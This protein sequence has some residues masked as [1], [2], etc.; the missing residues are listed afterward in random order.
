[1]SAP[2]LGVALFSLGGLF[3]GRRL[4]LTGCLEQV[5]ALGPNQGI[6]LVGAQSLRSYPDVSDDEVR[7]F[8]AAVDRTGVVPVSY[9]AYLE[10]ARS[11]TRVLSPLEAVDLVAAEIGV[12]R[13]LGFPMLRVNLVPPEVL[14]ALAR[15]AERTGMPVVIELATEP[16][17][18]PAVAALVEELDRL[19]CPDL[20]VIQDF[21]AFVQAIPA[22]YV[23]DA[24]AAG[25]PAAALDAITDAWSGGR[26][27][28][29]AVTTVL[30]L[31][32][33]T[34]EERGLSV[35]TAHIAY[36]LFRA[37]DPGGLRDVLPHL[38]HVQ[39]KFFALDT[40]DAE[41]CIPCPELITALREGGYTGRIHSE[42]EGF[43]WDDDLDAVDQI[44]RQQ[45]D[46]VRLWNGQPAPGR[47][48]A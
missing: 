7:E 32:G 34:G 21:S 10:R 18:D 4:T 36:A 47:S 17:T 6:E 37:G 44:T 42:F 13:R 27:V 40:D 9:C 20:G 41:P 11:S 16:R 19:A 23:A 12:A 30:E 45:R 31:P 38:R 33:L 2:P 15:L 3:W 1:M 26:A 24:A 25:T 48:S 29:E 35:Q 39:A 8:R 43:L 22:P 5:A 14:P 28:G 46:I